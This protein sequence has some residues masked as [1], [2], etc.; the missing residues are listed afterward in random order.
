MYDTRKPDRNPYE[1]SYFEDNPKM[2]LRLQTRS[3]GAVWVKSQLGQGYA[4][5][6]EKTR[7]ANVVNAMAGDEK[8]YNYIYSAQ[9]FRDQDYSEESPKKTGK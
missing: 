5:S 1:A 7:Q 6:D 4:I 3:N 8:H 2:S 9:D